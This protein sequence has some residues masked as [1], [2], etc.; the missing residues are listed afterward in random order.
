[1]FAL[2][3]VAMS[4]GLD[5]FGASTA[6][7]VSGVDRRLR[8]HVAVI[9]GVFEATMP[10]VG[11]LL[12]HTLARDL[13]STTKF[14]GG[15]LLVL[16]GAYALAS[17]YLGERKLVRGL[18]PSVKRLVVIAA[19]LSIDNLV[20][21]SRSAPIAS[22]LSSRPSPSP[23]SVSRCRCLAWRSVAVSANA[24]DDEVNSSAVSCS[25]WLGL[26]SHRACCREYPGLGDLDERV[27]YEAERD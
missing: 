13:G 18:E 16:A 6:M 7:G 12:G 1:M 4:V 22:I 10:V 14:I 19:A 24:S 2:L 3:L 26:L 15:G 17:D 8:L 11:L 27:E 21:A 5:N 20:V 23:R 25:S 9:F